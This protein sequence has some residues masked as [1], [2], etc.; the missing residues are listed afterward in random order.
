VQVCP[1]CGE[2]NP[3]RFRLCGFC[4]T[5][6]GAQVPIHEV[7]KT[8]TVVFSDLKG[9]T[10]L[11]ER[12]DSE[13]LREVMSRYFDA[14]RGVLEEHGGTIEKFIGDAVMAVF[15]LPRVHEDDA[16]RAVRAAAGM[17]SA[18]AELNDELERR[19]GV[20]LVNRTGVNTGEVV[21]GD[22][23]AGQRLITGDT[24]NVA[25][26]LEQ[27][28]PASEVLIGEPTNRLVRDFGDVEPVEPLELKG[29]Q[30]RV[31]AYRLLGVRQAERRRTEG[32]LVGREQELATLERALGDANRL[33]TSVLV[34]LLGEPG[35]GKTRLTDEFA[36]ATAVGA[37]FLRGRCL[38][39]GRGITFW[40]L[41]EV[42]RDAAGIREEDSP[43]VARAKLAALAPDAPEAVDRVASA[44]GLGLADYPLEEIYW[45]SR[46]LFESLARERAL[47]ILIE[48]IHWAEDAFLGLIERLE[49]SAAAPLLLLCTARPDLLERRPDWCP[50]SH[51]LELEPLSATETTL[52][53]EQLLGEPDLPPEVTDRIGRASE[54]NPLFVEQLI[55]MI[56]DDGLLVRSADGWRVE[57]DISNLAIPDSI[58]ALL[59][60]RL[61]LLTAEERAIL[62]P[63]SVVG[64]VFRRAAVEALAD[65]AVRGRSTLLLDGLVE[66][67][68][69]RRASGDVDEDAY[70]FH[71]NLVRDTAYQSLL[72]R[73]RATLHERFADWAEEVNRQRD[74]ELEFAEILGY[75]LERAYEYFGELGPLDDHALGLGRRAAGHLSSAGRRAFGRGDMGAAANLLRRAAQLL[76]ERHA[77]RIALL[78]ELGEAMMEIGEFAWAELYL[79]EAAAGAREMGDPVVEADAL[80]TRL[81]VQHHALDDLGA[82]RAEV[83]QETTRLIPIL[84]DHVA[85]AELAKAW[86]MVAFVHGTICR[87]EEAAAA[88]QLALGYARRANKRRQEARL[89]A[90]YTISLRDGPT[91]VDEAI[92]LCEEIVRSGLVDRQAEGVA[93]SS[94]AVL[95]ALQGDFD[96]ARDSYRR[97]YATLVDLGGALLAA[98]TSLTSGR[99]EMLAGEPAT[100]EAALRRDYDA[101]GTLGE[102]Y[103]RPLVGALLARALFD[104]D[105]I[106]EADGIAAEVRTQAAEDDVE[107]QA[108]SRS[109]LARVAA[110]RGVEHEALRFIDEAITALDETDAP[111][112]RADARVD[113]SVILAQ[114]GRHAEGVERLQQAAEL[115]D[116][117]GARLQAERSTLQLEKLRQ[118]SAVVS[119]TV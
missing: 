53:L 21:A 54:G 98:H 118:P 16:L 39:Y 68:L 59:S 44:V 86:R 36:Q 92:A 106:D 65:D 56:V 99:V 47:I 75:H 14:M 76:P 82:W 88:Q 52:V 15:G 64:M 83:T 102:R 5:A 49:S 108:L 38:P 87:W 73:T 81:L 101:L 58:H 119:E 57:G 116:R 61:E 90:A 69:V 55:S 20:R 104:Q 48:D 107:T 79:D 8:V 80:L 113:A 19:Y 74:R 110:L 103:F 1:R 114:A 100:A 62:E 50:D 42:V 89:A 26:R 96:T 17:K 30:E 37:R 95:Q 31:P 43:E 18:L 23:S 70:Q 22:P 105:R 71:H 11:G 78:P 117:K 32:R 109:V 10:A 6:L 2:E 25:A 33:H 41:L 67:R 34:T 29:K 3:P 12:L 4:G 27:A 13:A 111:V 112:T 60:A 72:K 24:V 28:A 45:G 84:E 51:R 9:S 40:P 46:R 93:L 35:V 77:D 91:P 97:A 63:A 66:K 115:Y 7:R 94:L 85:T